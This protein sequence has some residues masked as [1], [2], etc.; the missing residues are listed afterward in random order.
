MP[1]QWTAYSVTNGLI[2]Y[3]PVSWAYFTNYKEAISYIASEKR[4]LID[5]EY[6]VEGYA[7]DGYLEFGYDTDSLYQCY[8]L[9]IES[10]ATKAERDQ[11]IMDNEE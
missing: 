2:G 1:R 9:G 11:F 10:F 5:D 4:N 3:M 6:H 7:K 8:D